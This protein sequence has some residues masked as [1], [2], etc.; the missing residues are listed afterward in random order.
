M[1]SIIGLFLLLNQ[2]SPKAS[3][4]IALA[5][6]LG[7]FGTGISW[8]YVVIEKFGGLPT[9]VGLVLIGLLILYL[10]LYPALFGYLINKPK[11]PRVQ[12]Y[13]LLAP[14][15]WLLIDW[16]RGVM[17]TGFPWLW[18]GYSQIESPFA[19][20]APV[21]GVQGITLAIVLFAGAIT[22]CLLEKKPYY[23]LLS[24]ALV[25]VGLTGKQIQW[26]EKTGNEV[27]VAMIQGNVP[28]ELKWLPEYRWPTLLSYQDMTRANWDADLIIWPEAAVPAFENELPLFISR[29]DSAAFN[30]NTAIITG[31]LD[32]DDNGKYFNNVITLGKNGTPGYQYPA[33]QS[34]SKHHLLVFGE[35][36]L[37]KIYS[38][39]SHLC[40][41]CPCLPLQQAPISNR[42]SSRMICISHPRSV[43]KSH[44]VNKFAQISRQNQISF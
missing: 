41:I 8:V 39:P 2:Q 30:N 11:L 4:L 20:F 13:L 34:Y 25:A 16:L 22:L 19:G 35:F 32:R 3:A 28:Q 9:P 33:P 15:L 44:S 26:V 6:G 43:M 42:I 38:A 36:V 12:T 31:I 40:S 5:W 10:A 18:A 14:S 7:H 23:L 29:L 37:L 1:L 27:D 17:F 24:A 21:F